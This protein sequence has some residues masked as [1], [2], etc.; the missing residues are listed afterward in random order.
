[1]I[2]INCTRRRGLQSNVSLFMLVGLQGFLCA[3]TKS[4]ELEL[5]SERMIRE[6]VRIAWRTRDPRNAACT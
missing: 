6:C 2:F 1:M 4:P 3:I 5:H